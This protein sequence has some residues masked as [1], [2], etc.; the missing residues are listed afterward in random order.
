V[1]L[2]DGED[3]ARVFKLNIFDMLL[4]V[5]NECITRCWS[6][7]NRGNQLPNRDW[8]QRQ[9]AM[10]LL[11]RSN[12]IFTGMNIVGRNE[13]ALKQMFDPK[14]LPTLQLQGLKFQELGGFQNLVKS[15]EGAEV[16]LNALRSL[17]L[18]DGTESSIEKVKRLD[19]HNC[20]TPASQR[21]HKLIG[22][23][24]GSVQHF[25]IKL[26]PNYVN[27]KFIFHIG[28]SLRETT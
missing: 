1:H 4:K 19:N 7:A 6:I 8:N 3:L 14:L 9:R 25:L 28:M 13:Q 5:A 17:L 26:F 20:N 2:F 24:Q 22:E 11:G 27:N 12:M 15:S 18:L 21:L 23:N 10:F 16:I